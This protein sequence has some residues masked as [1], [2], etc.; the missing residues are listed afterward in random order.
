MKVHIVGAGPTGLTIAWNLI[1]N[2]YTVIV[3][4]KKEGPG[5]SW[6]EPEGERNYHAFRSVFRKGF[7][8]TRNLLQQMGLKWSNY[9]GKVPSNDTNVL[10]YFELSD[11]PKVIWL[12]LKV[13]TNPEKY[14]KINLKDCVENFSDVSKKLFEH[15]PYS[16]DGVCWC[17]MTAYEFFQSINMVTFDIPGETQIVSGRVMFTD[18]KNILEAKGVIFKFDKE[19]LKVSYNPK[20]YY[21]MFTDG[22]EIN[23]GILVLAVDNGP[24]RWLIDDNWGERAQKKL[25]SGMYSCMNILLYYD[26]IMAPLPKTELEY[27]IGSEL[28]ILAKAY[29]NTISCLILETDKIK[30]IPSGPL[31]E[32]VLSQTGLPKPIESKICWGSH[33]NGSQW[34]HSQT[35]GAY[36]LEGTLPFFG[37]SSRVALVGMMSPR[38]TPYASIEAATEVAN[39]FTKETFGIGKVYYPFTLVFFLIIIS[40]IITFMTSNIF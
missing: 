11:Y 22:H 30:N 32:M 1:N 20:S 28:K 38:Q 9:F 39:A 5:G 24:A 35:S 25:E 3:Y 26:Q 14:K 21:A 19:L 23:D 17:R 10:K 8:N 2:G 29:D 40:F 4:D 36:P 6:W 13:F 15:L 33:W 12:A 37:K 27:C 18:M 16:I 31:I 7:V 34:T